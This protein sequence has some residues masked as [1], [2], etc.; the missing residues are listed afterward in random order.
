MA[1]D[2]RF[3]MRLLGGISEKNSSGKGEPEKDPLEEGLKGLG[4]QGLSQRVKRLEKRLQTLGEEIGNAITHGV[5]ALFMLFMLPF[6]SIRAYTRVPGGKGVLEAVTTSI[7]VICIFFM[8]LTSTI[9]HSMSHGSAQKKVLRQLDHIMI[10]FAIAGTYT[11]IALTVIGGNLGIGICIAQ[12]ILVIGGILFKSLAFS[13]SRKAW[14]V[15]IFIYLLMGWMVALCMP[16]LML[17]ATVP[18]FWL[19]LAGGLCYTVGVICFSMKFPFSHMVWHF[20]VDFG[21]ICHF[22]AIVFFLY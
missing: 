20:F 16:A 7:F 15:T 17:G 3:W 4:P 1:S 10:Y 18:A 21:A 13:H 5:M 11:P 22:I 6:A 14:I 2:R 8:F 9:Y 12:W 19:I